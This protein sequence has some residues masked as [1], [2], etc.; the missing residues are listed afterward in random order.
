MLVIRKIC[1]TV[2][3]TFVKEERNYGLCKEKRTTEL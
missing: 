1:C 2:H 3:S